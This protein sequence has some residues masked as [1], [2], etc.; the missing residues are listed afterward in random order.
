MQGKGRPS[1][2]I[3]YAVMEKSKNVAVVPCDIGWS[4]V[5][6]WTALA[7]VHPHKDEAGNAM[8]GDAVAI[9][10]QNVYV[11]ADGRFIAAV[12]VRDLVV[13]DT[14][15]A[16]LVTHKD[17]SQD[18]KAVVDH[19]RRRKHAAALG[20]CRTC[21]LRGSAERLGAVFL[22]GRA[23]GRGR[24]APQAFSADGIGGCGDA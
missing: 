3:D 7:E 14:P 16:L 2:S 5:G 6:N 11:Q 18:V 10:S 12:G 4:D 15:D 8:I 17:T 21:G 20:V 19:L 9:N 24:A 23:L 1:V 22:R 13:V